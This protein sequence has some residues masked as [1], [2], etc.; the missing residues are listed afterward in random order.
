MFRADGLQLPD[1]RPAPTVGPNQV[2]DDLL[3]AL[4]VSDLTDKNSLP[5]RGSIGESG[6]CVKKNTSQY[7]GV[8]G[9]PVARGDCEGCEG[10]GGGASQRL[11]CFG[12][13]GISA[14]SG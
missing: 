2:V 10:R 13:A 9:Y 3:N 5:D 14:Q 8:L 7:M 12:V 6:L 11:K 4:A 1:H